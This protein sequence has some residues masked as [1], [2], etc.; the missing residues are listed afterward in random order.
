MLE[1]FP[2]SRCSPIGPVETLQEPLGARLKSY[3]DDVTARSP[4]PDRL[5]QLAAALEAALEGDD[6]GKACAGRKTLA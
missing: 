1:R 4:M 5:I 6:L 2:S 3:Y